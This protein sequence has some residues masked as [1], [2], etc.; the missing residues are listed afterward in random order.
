MLVISKKFLTKCPAITRETKIVK[1]LHFILHAVIV[2]KLPFRSKLS[3]PVLEDN[4]FLK[5]STY[6]T[7]SFLSAP[8]KQNPNKTY[9]E[10]IFIVSCFSFIFN[11][12]YFVLDM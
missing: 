9:I 4:N 12:R 2:S 7:N 11:S 10:D 1:M 8:V 5:K 3:C 6:M